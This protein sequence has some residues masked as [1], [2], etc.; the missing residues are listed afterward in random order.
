[1]TAKRLTTPRC[2]VCRHDERWRIELLRASGASLDTLAAKFSV[3]RDALWR[4]WRD[5]VTDEMKASYLAGPA[6]L[7]ELSAKAAEMGDSVLDHLKAVRTMLMAQLAALSEAGDA[8]GVAFVSGRLNQTLQ[9]IARVTGELG[10]LAGNLTIN[11]T[12]VAVGASPQFQAIQGVL[13]RALAPHPEARR[14]VVAALQQ[15]D[16]GDG[17]KLIEAEV[18]HAA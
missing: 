2:Q 11:Q 4:H 16:A 18:Q 7:H 9:L 14:D 3:H 6:Q 5:H 10:E 1:M 12:N 8:R 13:L 15:F 17:A